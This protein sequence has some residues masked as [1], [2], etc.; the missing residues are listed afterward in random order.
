MKQAIIAIDQGTTSTRTILFSSNFSIIYISQQE[1]AQIYPA[2][3]WVEHNP[4]TIW[5][6][7]ADT[8]CDVLNYATDNNIQPLAI[9]I[10]NQR[11]TTIVWDKQS[12]EAI[13]NAIVWQ[14]RRTADF[15]NTLQDNEEY[16]RKNTG[17]LLDP[18]FSGSKINW[19][20]N[21]VTGAR[22][23][24]NA[25]KLAFGTVDSFI[26]YKLTKGKQHLTDA[27]NASRT[28]LF[29]IQ[30]QQ[31]DHKLLDIFDIPKSMLP[32]VLDCA[33]DFGIAEIAGKKIPILG[34]AG[35]QQAATIGQCCFDKGSVKS[36]YG[37]G[38]FV[39][40]NT[41]DEIKYSKHKLLTTT[42]Y[43]LDNKTT[44]AV[45]GSI[46]IAGAAVQWLRD[47][48]NL[49]KT[50]SETEAICAKLTDNN[51]LYLIPAF[52]GLGAPHWDANARGALVGISRATNSNMLVRAA[53]ES[54]CYQTLDLLNA[55][56]TDGI[57]IKNLKVDGGMAAN[58]WMLQFLS[59]ILQLPINRPT[60]LETTALGVAYLAAIKLGIYQDLE[61]I[62]TN[63]QLDSNYIPQLDNA[64]RE[65]YI[66]GWKKA[67]TLV[68]AN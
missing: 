52:S 14:D 48:M 30:Q 33:D 53:I 62:K 40:V 65:K 57:E 64:N 39:L 2:D 47:E 23:K 3:G 54:V 13:Y 4:E 1:F 19:I 24:A 63:W 35:D 6:T 58:S 32:K 50:A 22:Q 49:I 42:A 9:G 26:T 18:Y 34:I 25:G 20:L 5:Q 46:F 12:G 41:G 16:I 56:K 55:I 44:Y 17:L 68:L 10:S 31:W 8:L 29:N 66:Q 36:T 7:V 37:T 45:E 21:N 28:Q 11:E 15:C 67:L 43:R 27:T 59:D 60:I 61:S 51:G 38:C